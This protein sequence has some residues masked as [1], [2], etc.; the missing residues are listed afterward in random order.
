MKKFF[1][2]VSVL[3]LLLVALLTTFSDWFFQ[4][5]F[6]GAKFDAKIWNSY[7][8]SE[9]ANSP[10]GPMT[11]D[12]IENHLKPGMDR[13]SVESLLGKEDSYQGQG[14]TGYTLGMWSGLAILDYDVLHVC[15]DSSDRLVSAIPYQH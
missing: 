7:A 14:C 10:R 9:E 2:T 11:N 6:S 15:F 5:P 3:L 1:K 8:N 12:L 4:S 13:Q